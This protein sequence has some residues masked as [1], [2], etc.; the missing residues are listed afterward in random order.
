[1]AGRLLAAL[2][3]FAVVAVLAPTAAADDGL[4]DYLR[5]ASD[6][7]F[8]GRGIVMCTWGVDSAAAT[9]EVTRSQG[10]SMVHGPGGELMSSGGISAMRSG[11]DWYAVEVTQW[12]TWQ[13]SDRYTI[14]EPVPTDRLGRAADQVLVLEGDLTRAR[15]IVDRGSTV[16]LVTEIFD[17]DGN[18]FR[19]AAMLEFSVVTELPSPMPSVP[20]TVPMMAAQPPTDLPSE[21]AGYHRSD[22]YQA[23]NE[24]VQAFLHRWVVHVFGLYRPPQWRPRRLQA[25]HRVHRRRRAVPADR[26]PEP[27]LGALAFPE[28]FLRDGRRPPTRPHRRRAPRHA[29]AGVTRVL[30]AAV[31]RAIRLRPH[32][33]RGAQRIGRSHRPSASC[34]WCGGRCARC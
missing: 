27:C 13:L 17:G 33:L 21:V 34:A 11:S 23:P 3:S 7:E 5:E 26:H 19:L 4:E 16:P 25:C 29:G 8:H 24:A 28:S 22:A 14:T 31:A 6:A 9:Y 2:S 30:L 15:L 20:G 10:M 18:L 12:A 32:A 1:M